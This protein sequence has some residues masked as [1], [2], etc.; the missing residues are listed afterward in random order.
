MNAQNVVKK[1]VININ[2]AVLNV[3]IVFGQQHIKGKLERY[4]R[5]R[6]SSWIFCIDMHQ[7]F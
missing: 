1:S 5:K 7:Q 3:I 4:D 2:I 6:N